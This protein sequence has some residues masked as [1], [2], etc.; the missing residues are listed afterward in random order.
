MEA[1]SDSAG[2]EA[3]KENWVKGGEAVLCRN[4]MTKTSAKTTLFS[5]EFGLYC[6]TMPVLRKQ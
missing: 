3:P 4:M 2:H 1:K 6:A 5:G